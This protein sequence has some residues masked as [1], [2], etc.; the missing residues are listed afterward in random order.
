MG[1]GDH[2]RCGL[3]ADRE[4]D[5]LLAGGAPRL[6]RRLNKAISS[7]GV[8]KTI[9]G[10]AA[11][12]RCRHR[13]CYLDAYANANVCVVAAPSSL[14]CCS[15]RGRISAPSGRGAQNPRQGKHPPRFSSISSCFAS[16]TGSLAPSL[17]VRRQGWPASMGKKRVRISHLGTADSSY[18]EPQ[19][20]TRFQS[21]AAVISYRGRT[22]RS[23][24]RDQSPMHTNKHNRGLS[25]L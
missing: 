17:R 12:P 8:A 4:L 3:L 5:D 16:T 19:P 24:R 10:P 25:P 13:P 15:A 14:C 21:S 18:L 9:A 2:F 1:H 20:A 22:L 23:K 7:V 11:A 6:G